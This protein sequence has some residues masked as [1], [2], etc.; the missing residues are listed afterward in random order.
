MPRLVSGPP[1]AFETPVLEP[2]GCDPTFE[3]VEVGLAALAHAT[4]AIA[5]T[6]TAAIRNGVLR[7]AAN[8]RI[9]VNLI[10]LLL[11]CPFSW[12]GSDGPFV[13]CRRCFRAYLLMARLSAVVPPGVARFLGLRYVDAIRGRIV[14][15]SSD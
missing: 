4:P 14:P 8:C 13:D 2:A 11:L 3:G 7:F 12:Y 15:L 1:M 6:L 5:S 10:V 9:D